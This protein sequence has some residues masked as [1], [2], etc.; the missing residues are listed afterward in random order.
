MAKSKFIA[1]LVRQ[2]ARVGELRTAVLEGAMKE[3]DVYAELGDVV[4]GTKQGRVAG[5]GL[6]VVDLTGTGAQDAAIGQVAWD[7]LSKL[8]WTH[9]WLL[10]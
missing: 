10:V 5:D 7:V 1:D 6:I 8:Q 2:C 3:S 9:Y 4:N